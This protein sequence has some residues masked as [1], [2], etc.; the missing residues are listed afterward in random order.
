MQNLER[1][2]ERERHDKTTN[3]TKAILEFTRMLGKKL[4]RITTT[5]TIIIIT[6][7]LQNFGNYSRYAISDKGPKVTSDRIFENDSKKMKT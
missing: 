7:F 4:K 1:Y 5:I 2:Q 3:A 6:Y